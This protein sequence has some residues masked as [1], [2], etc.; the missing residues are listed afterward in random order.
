MEGETNSSNFKPIDIRE[1]V[2][3]RNEKVAKQLPRF[4]YRWLEKILHL[5][6]INEFMM[7]SG[8]LEGVEF[9]KAIIEYTNISYTL[10][11]LENVTEGKRFMF[12]SNHPLGGL[13]GVILLRILNES[14]GTT[15]VLVNDFLMNITSFGEWFVPINK[16][17]GQARAALKKVEKLYESNDHVLMFPAGLCS[18]KID[19][20][21]VDLEWQKHFIQK[22]TQHKL[23]VIPIFFEGRN[24]RKF[25]NLARFR[26][27]FKIKFNIE[28]MYL[29]DEL[30][31]HKGKK[32]T[33]QFGKP[34]PYTTFDKSKK[35]IAWAQD[36][37]ETVYNLELT[38][39]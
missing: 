3:A 18:R 36:V 8:H 5:K 33:V 1:V 35:P 17:G 21:I 19:G 11:G 4:I 25:Y 27:F 32:F 31:K 34:I 20:E 38:N 23:D 7:K 2:A 15:R 39:H 9:A 24:S 22:S 6:E 16:I 29:V 14:F 26:K 37:K 28:M 13:D 12:V 10:S 30:Y